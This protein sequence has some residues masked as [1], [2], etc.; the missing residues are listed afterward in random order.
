MWKAEGVEGG[1]RMV[2][3]VTLECGG[4]AGREYKRWQGPIVWLVMDQKTFLLLFSALFSQVWTDK[5]GLYTFQI[6][7]LYR[8][9]CVNVKLFK[10]MWIQ[11][12][13]HDLS[14]DR[15]VHPGIYSLK[16][17]FLSTHFFKYICQLSFWAHIFS[18]TFQ[19]YGHA[20]GYGAGAGEVWKRASEQVSP[21]YF[22]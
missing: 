11:T 17:L 7:H 9:K 21:Q 16:K 4:K 13:L 6:F 10:Q 22:L 3:I 14:S 12:Y 2:I 20:P 15:Q 19:V 5:L 8:D 1:H 18:S